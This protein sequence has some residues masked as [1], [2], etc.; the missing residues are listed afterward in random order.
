M[1]TKKKSTKSKA[2][3]PEALATE[4]PEKV[5]V[6]KLLKDERTHKII[7]AVFMLIAFLLFVAFTSYLFTWDEDQ[8]KVINQ[9]LRLLKANDIKVNNLLGTFGAFISD[10]FVRRGFGVASYLFCTFFFTVSV[11]LFFGRKIFSIARNVKYVIIGL[12]VLSMAFAVIF[13]GK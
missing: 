13:N 7:G 1:A 12:V 3:D 5:E 2:T 9:G 4:T 11:N 10:F 6:K 8:D